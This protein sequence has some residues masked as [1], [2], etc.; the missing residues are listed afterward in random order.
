[1]TLVEGAVTDNL[2]N[3]YLIPILNDIGF[4]HNF[5]H[6]ISLLCGFVLVTSLTILFGD[7]IPKRIALVYPEA[8]A[9]HLAPVISKV[10]YVF[11]P[12]VVVFSYLSDKILRIFRVP[13]EQNHEVSAEDI[14]D[15]FEKVD[16]RGSKV[17]HASEIRWGVN[18]GVTN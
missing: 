4:L 7:I 16:G 11:S 15:L 3:P 14:E 10:V 1:M 6:F 2:L 5:S 18:S 8:I 12:L 9:V 13:T 17:R